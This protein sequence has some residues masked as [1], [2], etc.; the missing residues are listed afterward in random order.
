MVEKCKNRDKATPEL[1]P[2]TRINLD[3]TF[4][5]DDEPQYKQVINRISLMLKLSLAISLQQ[6]LLLRF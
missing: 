4:E 5:D 3:K 1:A 2:N 6:L